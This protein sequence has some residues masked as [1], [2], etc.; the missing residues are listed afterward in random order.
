MT[1]LCEYILALHARPIITPY[2][3][4]YYVT[5]YIILADPSGRMLYLSGALSKLIVRLPCYRSTYGSPFVLVSFQGHSVRQRA[6]P[7]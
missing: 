2:A 7:V 4:I 3:T 1:R 6:S 5:R